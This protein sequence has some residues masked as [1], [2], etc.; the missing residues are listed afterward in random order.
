AL[1][2]ISHVKE[3]V[4]LAKQ[5][6]LPQPIIDIIQQHHGTSVQSYFFQKAK[7]L[8]EKEK[9]LPPAAEDDFRYPGPKPKTRV[10]AL[11]HMADAVEAASRTLTD[12]TPTKISAMIDRIINNRIIDGQLDECELTLKDIREIKINFVFILSS[13]YHKRINY[14]AFEREDEDINKKPAAASNAGLGQDR[15]NGG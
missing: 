10:A 4:E 3:G 2:L 8:H 13:I 15:G 12:P 1:V 6:N 11:I 9:T 7:E 5:H 14:P